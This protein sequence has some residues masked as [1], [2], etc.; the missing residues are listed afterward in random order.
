MRVDPAVTPTTD[1]GTLEAAAPGW[2]ELRRRMK[3]LGVTRYR[4]EAEPDGA[5]RFSCLI[6]L[7][8]ERAVAQH[9]E[10]EADDEL[11]AADAALRRVALW[12]AARRR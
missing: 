3:E 7:A 8:G 1:T 5:A 12:R 2:P 10:A 4:V 6:P 9:F 11:K